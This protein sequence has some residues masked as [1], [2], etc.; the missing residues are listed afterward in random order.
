M[1]HGLNLLSGITYIPLDLD[2]LE[3]V[4]YILDYGRAMILMIW[5]GLMIRSLMYT[6][7]REEI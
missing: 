5:Y 7:G 2:E 3:S 6:I 4:F 1:L